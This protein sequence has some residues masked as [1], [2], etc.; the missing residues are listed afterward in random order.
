MT[1]ICDINILENEIPYIVIGWLID[2][3]QRRLTMTASA[4]GVAKICIFI[5]IIIS[6]LVNFCL[7]DQSFIITKQII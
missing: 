6:Y 3:S 2:I 1:G 7:T 4:A 5:H